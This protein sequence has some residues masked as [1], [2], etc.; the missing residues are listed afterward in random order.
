MYRYWYMYIVQNFVFV[1]LVLFKYYN[2]NLIITLINYYLFKGPNLLTDLFIVS[3][4][5]PSTR[6]KKLNI[7]L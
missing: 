1:R 2:L 3:P 6:V 7:G 4:C 5:P